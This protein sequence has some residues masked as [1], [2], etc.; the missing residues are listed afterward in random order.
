MYMQFKLATKEQ[1]KLRLAIF[2]PSGSGKT[3]SSLRIASGLGGKIALI[4][5]ERGSASKYADRFKFDVLE[6]DKKDIATYCKAIQLAKDYDILV[7][8]SLSHAWYTLLE[9]INKIAHSRFGGNTWAAWS[10]G[11]PKQRKLV[12]TLLGFDGHVIATMRTKT[13]W[14]M[15]K[16]DKGRNKPVRVGLAPE[17]GKNI[18]YEFDLLMELTVDHSASIL[19]DRT[20]RFQD[21]IIELPGE[22]FGQGLKNWLVEG[23]S[24]ATNEQKAEIMT[25]ITEDLGLA[26]IDDTLIK[27]NFVPMSRL[28]EKQATQV[29]ER[30]STKINEVKLAESK[31]A[32]EKEKPPVQI[33]KEAAQKPEKENEPAAI[34]QRQLI[35]NLFATCFDLDIKAADFLDTINT[36]LAGKGNRKLHEMG[37]VEAKSVIDAL[38]KYKTTLGKKEEGVRNE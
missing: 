26:N 6:L 10:Q 14:T 29:I 7:I 21:N 18:E 38:L 5:T 23:E 16:D 33:N 37:P 24:L 31:P 28:T 3:F 27:A 8:D 13:E 22:I 15:V 25:M 17:Q 36:R 4:D 11:T 1:A 9:E 12:D 2:G 34:Q 19:K 32:Q 30:L 20:G 35:K